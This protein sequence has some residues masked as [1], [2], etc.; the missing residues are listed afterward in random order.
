MRNLFFMLLIGGAAS[1]VVVAADP[2]KPT[3]P[4]SLDDELF[5]DLDDATTA[6][7]V[8]PKP[9]ATAKKPDAAPQ[10]RP[11]NPLDDELLKQLEGD[12][13]GAKSKQATKPSAGGEGRKGPARTA[14]DDPF[15]RLT[16]E[17]R[18]AEARLRRT[19]TGEET[20]QLQRKIVDDLEK[21][22]AQIEQQQQQRRQSQSQQ[23]KNSPSQP[24]P[25]QP[26]PQPGQQQQC[27]QE[28]SKA[29]DSQQGTRSTANRKADPGNLKSL[30]EKAWGSLP[31]RERQAV[32][33]S[34]VDDFPTKYQAV[35]E[36]YFKTLLKREE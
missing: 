14:S 33:Q 26:K 3:V 7:G 12:D 11:T 2:P 1:S 35:I 15:L 17:I 25:G 28:S 29:R 22:I 34:S 21:L 19:E 6:P 5:K 16:E 23:Q 10:P 9:S 8:K 13:P 24:Q 4:S 32:M 27:E 31:E 20:Q 36:E 30:L 18:D